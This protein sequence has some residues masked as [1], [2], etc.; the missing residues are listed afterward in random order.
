MKIAKILIGLSLAALPAF[1]S[2][3]LPNQW[4][5]FGWNGAIG[6]QALGGFPGYTGSQGTLLAAT[7]CVGSAP[8]TDPWTFSGN[9]SFTVQDLFFDGD[10]FDVWDNGSSIGLSSVPLNDDT[11]C[12]NDPLGCTSASFS[13]RTYVLGSGAHS[14]TIFLNNETA[15]ITSGVAAMKMSA[16]APPS[17]P[18]PA[19]MSLIGLG[20]VGLAFRWRTKRT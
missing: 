10:R 17:V 7:T 6:V 13:N 5:T 12:G 8:C 15:G 19:T 2:A 4:Y 16:L 1:S 14:I 3:L 11:A 9:A 20:L 18:E